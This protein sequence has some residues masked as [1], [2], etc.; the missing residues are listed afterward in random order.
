MAGL[1]KSIRDKALFQ[2]VFS[3]VLFPNKRNSCGDDN[4][5]ETNTAGTGQLS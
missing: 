2:E 1:A 4:C 5:I 3:T